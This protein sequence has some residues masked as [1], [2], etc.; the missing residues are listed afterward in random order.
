MLIGGLKRTNFIIKTANQIQV[1]I[2]GMMRQ[3]RLR[4]VA[5]INERPRSFAF[6]TGEK[7][8]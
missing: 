1:I 7:G 6:V 3:R 5:G 4:I 2:F 8:L